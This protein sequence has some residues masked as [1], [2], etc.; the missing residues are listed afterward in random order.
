ME[1]SRCINFSVNCTMVSALVAFPSAD[2]R[3]PRFSCVKCGNWNGMLI[4]RYVFQCQV[5]LGFVSRVGF[6]SS[7]VDR[8]ISLV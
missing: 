6:S 3:E 8:Q 1:T 5:R 7:F 4:A 2:R